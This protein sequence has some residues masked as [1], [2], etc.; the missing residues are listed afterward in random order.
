MNIVT[1]PIVGTFTLLNTYLNICPHQA[2][3]RYIEKVIPFSE[4]PE[5]RFGN[6]VHTAFEHRIRGGKPLPADMQQWEGFARP[7]DGKQVEVEQKLGV[8]LQ[9]KPTGSYSN[10]DFVRGK[11]DLTAVAG[12]VGYMADWKTGNSKYESPFELEIGAMLLHAKYPQ[13]K[14]I[15]GQYVWLKENRLGTVYDLSNTAGTW[16]YV[17][18]TMMQVKVDQQAGEFEKRKG[19][20]CKWCPVFACEHNTHPDNT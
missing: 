5:I 13:L 1:R 20:L 9:G 14:K 12:A 8:T 10:E 15:V 2:S 4:T 3:K 19:P 16:Q 18:R 6:Q 17:Y 7:F 11:L